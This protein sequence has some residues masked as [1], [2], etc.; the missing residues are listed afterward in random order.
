MR[1]GDL[2]RLLRSANI[3]ILPDK[4]SSVQMANT[5][6]QLY[7]QM[8]FAVRGRDSLIKKE[9]KEDLYKYTTGI[10]QNGGHKM[11]AI[12]GMP[13]H[14]HI[15]VGYNPNQKIPDLVETIK[16]DTNHFIKNQ[17]LTRHKFSW[18]SG[19]GA[20]SYSRSHIDRLIQ[21][22]LNQEQ[23]HRKTTF[24]AEY[25]DL[26]QKFEIEYQE[27]YLFEFIDDINSW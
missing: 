19:Y 8:V 15:F 24:R 26:L 6:T 14:V 2:L 25:L 5:Y 17:G 22:I 21:Y 9:W 3:I 10:V 27:P 18:Q 12:N 4:Q 20:F 1:E 7:I 11:L 13:D 16:T 23:H